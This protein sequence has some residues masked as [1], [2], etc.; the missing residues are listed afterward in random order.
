LLRAYRHAAAKQ[1]ASLASNAQSADC[2]QAIKNIDNEALD[3][4][5]HWCL[6]DEK[7]LHELQK[8]CAA[9]FL[10]PA[11]QRSI[12]GRSLK[13]WCE[14]LGADL[15]KTV[16]D[17]QPDVQLADPPALP[18]ASEPLMNATGASVLLSTVSTHPAHP[19]LQQLIGD[20]NG[21]L[22]QQLAMRIYLAAAS[23]QQGMARGQLA[24]GDDCHDAEA[25]EQQ[26]SADHTHAP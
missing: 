16:L 5:P 26:H 3:T 20:H 4:L 8:I 6:L 23:L 22:D 18:V 15:F 9:V 1:L 7:S 25:L 21:L 2:A 14:L 12:D 10:A 19:L 13:A 11:L 24:V 17:E